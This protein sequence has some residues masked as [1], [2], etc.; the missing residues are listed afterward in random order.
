MALVGSKL[1]GMPLEKAVC[2]ICKIPAY[3]AGFAGQAALHCAECKGLGLKRE[4]MMKLQ[5]YGT[6]DI[7]LGLDERQHK[8]PPYFEPRQKPPFLICPFCK[9]RMKAV[10]LGRFPADLCE[11]CGSLWLE[12]GKLPYINDMLGP[13]KWKVSKEKK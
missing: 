9:K 10:T 4:S 8:R 1:V 13:Y 2:P 11:A 7:L 5:P 3:E 6:K 12:E